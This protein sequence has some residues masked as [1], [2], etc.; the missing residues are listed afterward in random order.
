VSLDIPRK[1]DLGERIADISIHINHDMESSVP[2]NPPRA[3]MLDNIDVKSPD[4]TLC[5]SFERL[6]IQFNFLPVQK[7]LLQA[8]RLKPDVVESRQDM[9]MLD[10]QEQPNDDL[11]VLENVVGDMFQD[12]SNSMLRCFDWAAP[13]SLNLQ[14]DTVQYSKQR[15]NGTV[16]NSPEAGYRQ[17]HGVKRGAFPPEVTNILKTWIRTH[18]NSLSATKEDMQELMNKTGLQKSKDTWRCFL[19]IQ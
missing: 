16:N 1:D 15:S 9:M 2:K 3:C 17:Q 8:K 19:S 13:Q 6:Q 10:L 12:L 5:A 18:S 14:T 4:N 7:K 11:R